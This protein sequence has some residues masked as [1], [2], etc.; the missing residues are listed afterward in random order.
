M[1]WPRYI[2]CQKYQRMACFSALGNTDRNAQAGLSVFYFENNFSSSRLF[3]LGIPDDLSFWASRESKLIRMHNEELTLALDDDIRH[4]HWEPLKEMSNFLP[5]EKLMRNEKKNES[6]HIL[7][8]QMK[9]KIFCK[10][11]ESFFN[12]QK[13]TQWKRLNWIVRLFT[14]RKKTKSPLTNWNIDSEFFP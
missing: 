12:Q 2:S 10:I 11:V 9:R 4:S 7:K 6:C 14:K 3:F 5:I 8:M 13:K 1:I